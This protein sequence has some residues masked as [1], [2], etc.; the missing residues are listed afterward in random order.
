M[1]ALVELQVGFA[2]VKIETN[3]FFW[4]EHVAPNF[5]HVA[6]EDDDHDGDNKLSLTMTTMMMMILMNKLII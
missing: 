1:K 3:C 6:V 2:E 5:D 4:R